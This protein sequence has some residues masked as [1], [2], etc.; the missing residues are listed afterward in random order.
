MERKKPWTAEHA[1]VISFVSVGG[2]CRSRDSDVGV[3][4]WSFDEERPISPGVE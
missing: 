3:V 2:A 1:Y 4:C